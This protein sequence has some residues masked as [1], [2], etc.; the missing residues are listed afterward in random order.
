MATDRTRRI[1]HRA[2]MALCATVSAVTFILLWAPLVLLPS[3]KDAEPGSYGEMVAI[4]TI[5]AIVLV[6]AAL[7]VS[8]FWPMRVSAPVTLAFLVTAVGIFLWATMGDDRSGVSAL[9][10]PVG[11]ASSLLPPLILGWLLG[12]TI[13]PRRADH[14]LQ[15]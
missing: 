11:V 6:G 2:V 8:R 1:V 12:N 15:Q 9:V 10:L 3:L 4:W 5:T 7:V 13:R 14:V